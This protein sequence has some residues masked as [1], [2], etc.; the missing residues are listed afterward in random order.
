MLFRDHLEFE[1]HD[2]NHGNKRE[3]E[4]AEEEEEE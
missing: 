3:G 1:S 4:D 2:D